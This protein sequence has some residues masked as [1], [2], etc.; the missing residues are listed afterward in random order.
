MYVR[1]K[2]KADVYLTCPGDKVFIHAAVHQ[3]LLEIAVK[4]KLMSANHTLVYE[5]RKT[6]L[7]RCCCCCCL[8]ALHTG[9]CSNFCSYCAHQS[10]FVGLARRT[11]RRMSELNSHQTNKWLHGIVQRILQG[12]WY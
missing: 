8:V 10:Q 7:L 5:V 2:T 4:M 1:V 9:P 11:S 12:E 6:I 3:G